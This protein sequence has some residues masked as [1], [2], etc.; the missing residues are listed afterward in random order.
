MSKKD[1]RAEHDQREDL[2]EVGPAEFF[3]NSRSGMSREVKI[4]MAV[5]VVLLTILGVLLVNRMR[6][7]DETATAAADAQKTDS[8]EA[9][10]AAKD[11][12]DSSL[13][14]PFSS[15]STPTLVPAKAGTTGTGSLSGMPNWNVSTDTSRMKD[16]AAGGRA[17][18][19]PPSYMP[20]A[21]TSLVSDRSPRYGN[22]T[23]PDPQARPWQSGQSTTSISVGGQQPFDPFPRATPTTPNDS[24]A[25]GPAQPGGT[26]GRLAAAPGPVAPYANRYSTS[27]AAPSTSANAGNPLRDTSGAMMVAD[28][29]AP[30]PAASTFAAGGASPATYRAAAEPQPLAP[31][32]AGPV[33]VYARSD[34]AASLKQGDAGRRADGTYVVQPNDNFWRISEKLYGTGAYFRA[35]A[36]HN[37]K[38]IPDEDRLSVGDVILAPPAAELER[39]FPSLCPKPEHRLLGQDR[40]VSNPSSTRPGARV[41]VVQEGDNLFN[42]AKYELKSPMRWP[43]IYELNRQLLGDQVDRLTPGMKLTLPDTQEPAGVLTQQP[44]TTLRR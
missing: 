43:E 10:K 39:G 15:P 1:Q 36:E 42:I 3:P 26:S 28:S 4:G 34:P 40:L 44:G 6:R 33:A 16:V 35:L 7:S 22:T 30:L 17:E 29:P 37:Y 8:R 38:K 19:S 14:K 11:A 24:P 25:G 41:Y 12:K 27:S 21:D 32:P 23:A 31:Q 9:G 20:K 18:S 5:I 13:G 2:D